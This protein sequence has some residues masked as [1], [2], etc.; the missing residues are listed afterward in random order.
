[1]AVRVLLEGKA[2][3]HFCIL[4]SPV[5]LLCLPITAELRGSTLHSI[6]LLESARGAV[7]PA[8]GDPAL[9]G[10]LGPVSSRGPFQLL[11]LSESMVLGVLH[12]I[13]II[14]AQNHGSMEL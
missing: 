8:L 10:A 3:Q 9:L 13:G 12:N 4:G 5:C 11:V 14:E 7:G 6:L 2:R 1:M